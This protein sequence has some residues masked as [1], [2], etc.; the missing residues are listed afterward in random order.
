MGETW[1]KPGDDG[2][3]ECENLFKSETNMCLCGGLCDV[4]PIG[5]CA[6]PTETKNSFERELYLR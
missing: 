2:G 3:I 6:G 4:A 1:R 5:P